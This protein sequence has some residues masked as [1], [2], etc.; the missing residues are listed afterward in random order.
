MRIFNEDKTQELTEYDLTTGYLDNDVLI[1]HIPE[2]LEVQEE[3]HEEILAEY[4]NGGKEV[5]IIV[6]TPYSPYIAAHD[7]EEKILVYKK[8]NQT[9]LNQIRIDELK[10]MLSSTDY[11]AIK[12]AEGLISNEDYEPIKNQRQQWRDEI[13]R[14]EK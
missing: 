1:K 8:Y 2:Q 12:F 7:E 14:L 4:P 5:E 6:D 11:Q 13:N 10:A 3:S 9:E